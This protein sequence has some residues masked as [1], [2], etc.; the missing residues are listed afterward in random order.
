MIELRGVLSKKIRSLILEFS[1]TALA[2]P[3]AQSSNGERQ[4]TP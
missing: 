4:G 3:D 2:E 1:M